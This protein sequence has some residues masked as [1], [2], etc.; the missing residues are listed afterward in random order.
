MLV[1][2]LVPVEDEVFGICD[3]PCPIRF[4]MVV[5]GLLS[6][7]LWQEKEDWG[8]WNKFELVDDYGVYLAVIVF[9]LQ[10]YLTLSYDLDK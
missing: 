9:N 3:E 10:F 1:P 8:F 7:L 4:W 6:S 2:L 5:R